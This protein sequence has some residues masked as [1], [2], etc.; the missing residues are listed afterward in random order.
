MTKFAFGKEIEQQ[1]E[2]AALVDE[3]GIF[4]SIQQKI[5]CFC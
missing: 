2:D 4:L 3:C 1:K 5:V